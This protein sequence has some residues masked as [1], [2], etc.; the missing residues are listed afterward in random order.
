MNAITMT[1]CTFCEWLAGVGR[2]IVRFAEIASYARA[3]AELTRQGMHADSKALMI[4][5]TKLIGEK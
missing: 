4:E 2:G 1:Y 3:A 5:K